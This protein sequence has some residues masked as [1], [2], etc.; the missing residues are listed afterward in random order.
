MRYK[1]TTTHLRAV[2][3]AAAH[4]FGDH[5]HRQTLQLRQ[6]IAPEIDAIERPVIPPRRSGFP[7]L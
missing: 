4:R 1:P 5:A 6:N 3:S 7:L 2:R